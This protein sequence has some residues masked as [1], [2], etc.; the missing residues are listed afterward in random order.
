M[1]MQYKQS[2]NKTRLDKLVQCLCNYTKSMDNGN[3]LIETLRGLL[4]NPMPSSSIT[5]YNSDQTLFEDE[6]RRMIGTILS[7]EMDDNGRQTS[8]KNS[9][10]ILDNTILPQCT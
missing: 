5:N 8:S 4:S 3:V 9:M 7:E 6:N 10:D 2:E 1:M